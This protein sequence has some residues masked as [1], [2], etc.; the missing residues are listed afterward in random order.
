M[1]KSKAERLAEVHARAIRRFNSIWVSEQDMR[2]QCNEDRR[3]C[4]VPGAQWE[5]SLA[6]QFENRPRFEINKVFQSVQQAI[7]EYRNNRISPNFR[8]A[9]D[10]GDEKIA[11]TLDG[12][13]RADEQES[14]AQEAYDNAFSEMIA[15]GIGA[16]RLRAEL[17]D[18]DDEDNDD[19]RI[20]IEPIFDADTSVFF[21][22][23]HRQDKSDATACFVI[24]G[25]QRDEY[26]DE[27]GDES[28]TSFQDTQIESQYDWFKPD[29]VFVAEYYEIEKK[30]VEYSVWLDHLTNEEEK[31]LVD[32]LDADMREELSAANKTEIRSETKREKRVH[33]Y[34]IDGFRVIEDLGFIAGKH[35]PIVI[36][37]GQRNF[38]NGVERVQGMV[39]NAKDPQRIY[40]MEVST[41]VELSAM[42]SRVKPIFAPEQ[43]EGVSHLWASDNID[44]NPFLL[45]NPLRNDDGSIVTAGPTGMTQDT[46][47]PQT[48]A[49][50]MQVCNADVQEVLGKNNNADQLKANVSAEAVELVQKRV[51]MA[52]FI[53]MDNFA[54]AMKRSGE[55]WLSIAKEAYNEPGK[56]MRTV[57][58]DGTDG[59]VEIAKPMHNGNE[60]VT[61]N[62]IGNGRFNVIADVGP[63]FTSRRDA[64]VKALVNMA[65]ATPDQDMQSVLYGVALLNMDGEGIEDVKKYN[66]RNLVAKGVVEPTEEEKAEM[67][68]QAQQQ[69]QPSPQDQFMM[70]E[71][72][73]SQA[74]AAKA[75]ADAEKSKAETEK[76]LAE[77]PLAEREQILKVID[78]MVKARSN[79][80]PMQ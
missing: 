3:F 54:K 15:G 75:V 33:K 38:I 40:N 59:R 73:K 80:M 69:Q 8:P 14:G 57:G 7:S 66:R 55:I 6:S 48:L 50:M 74:L 21:Y 46:P 20:R 32:E 49:T 53:Y 28:I 1:A 34:I 17:E 27:Y 61:E 63:S 31:Y 9:D 60:L 42:N 37:Y 51:D 16:W 25:Y 36:A 65:Q 70:A 76:I 30:K 45:A 29:L 58:V 64:T 44:N 23:S 72:Q 39:R 13:Y 62:D 19:I 78:Q 35:I 41:L 79:Q 52:T 2:T 10:M 68:A 4:F 71:A 18:E 5:G 22:G 24:K 47:V 56:I 77:I 12:L 26:I 43:M 11:D 67:Q